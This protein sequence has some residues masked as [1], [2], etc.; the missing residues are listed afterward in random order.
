MGCFTFLFP[1]MDLSRCSD[2]E[3]PQVLL[4]YGNIKIKTS[5]GNQ[6][7]LEKLSKI[8]SGREELK[9]SIFVKTCTVALE[10]LWNKSLTAVSEKW[11]VL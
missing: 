8:K 11:G 5:H 6:F 4:N 9:T 2:D 7:G 1:V 10:K 3:Q